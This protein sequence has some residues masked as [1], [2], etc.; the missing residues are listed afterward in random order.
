[1]RGLVEQVRSAQDPT[2]QSALSI[3]G[4]DILGLGVPPGPQVGHIL[5]NL[6]NDV[7]E[8]PT[9]NQRDTLL[10]RAKEYAD[11]QPV[12]QGVV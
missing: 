11:A 3:N 1:M 9:L 5:R 2:Q 10:Q 6:T 7:I 8:D 12:Q 4:N